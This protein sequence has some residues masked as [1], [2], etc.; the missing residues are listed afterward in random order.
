MKKLLTTALAAIAL[1]APAAHAQLEYK[2]V[3]TIKTDA[4][5]FKSSNIPVYTMDKYGQGLTLYSSSFLGLNS[6]SNIKEISYYGW[7]S[8]KDYNYKYTL[9]VANTDETDV[10]S[11]IIDGPAE[12][13]KATTIV[14]ISR[15]T[16][17]GEINLESQ[18]AIGSSTDPQILLTFT[19]DSGFE[20]TG[21]N[22]IFFVEM[23][24]GMT[25]GISSSYATFCLANNGNA[26]K[27]SVSYRYSPYA[28]DAYGGGYGI[29]T[30]SWSPSR[31][32]LPVM[33]IGYSG[34]ATVITATVNG[35][36]VSSRNQAGLAGA[37]VTLAGQTVTTPSSGLYSFTI[38]NVDNSATYTI[39]VSA[40]GYES[41]SQ[42]VDLR[43]GGE[44]HVDDIVLQ[45]LP[46]PATI[47]GKVLDSS[48]NT[49]VAGAS[50]LFNGTTTVSA[51]DGAYSIAIANV[52]DLPAEGSPLKV[53]AEGFLPYE[54]SLQVTGDM[55]M[56]LLIEPIPAL[57]GNGTLIGSWSLDNF[58]YKAPF[59]PLWAFSQT[60]TLYPT[61]MFA[62]VAA[63]SKFDS[64][65]FYGYYPQSTTP[66]GG[67]EGGDEDDDWGY[68]YEAP[69]RAE[70]ESKT[71][72]V[73][74]YMLSVD[75]T[76]FAVGDSFIPVGDAE[77]LYDG[78]VTLTT[79]G[80]A[81]HP[82]ELFK[83]DFSRPFEYE[84]RPVLLYCDATDG[85]SALAYFCFDG[86]FKSQVLG[87]SASNE[88][89]LETSAASLYTEGMP[90]MRLGN[91]VEA[92]TVSGTVTDIS[93]T[94]PLEGVA[95][96]LTLSGRTVGETV[97]DALGHYSI[98]VSDVRYGQRY[99][100]SFSLDNYDDERSTI[101]FTEAEP[102]VTCDMEM[103]SELTVGVNGID[104]DNSGAD[105]FTVTG[106]RVLTGATA[107]DIDRLPAGIYICRGKKIIVK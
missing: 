64:V 40:E 21:G 98:A 61:E 76:A 43:A 17:F 15:M 72:N 36:V 89:T 34:Q 71:F 14:D 104:A 69:A 3:G 55:N 45:K 20:Y 86:A 5:E 31:S 50:I 7:Q 29:N 75:E 57:P 91:Y 63:G 25:S 24:D 84:G 93:T 67:D 79:G 94:F 30:K 87:R 58:D 101:T 95:V 78:P 11:F 9:Y 85:A 92:P 1:A 73:K 44:I 60:Q 42:T 103:F 96:K 38:P 82:V 22:L 100:L 37:T 51:A 80:E 2:Q 19:C 6:G 99:Q 35:R 77:P 41:T 27:G 49:A 18:E 56:N 23:N 102:D 32:N 65:S 88:P 28:P 62:G 52:D 54:T 53:T 48:N 26:N 107:D 8:A 105:V 16:K 39:G 13:S 97:T 74:L 106:V 90:V 70:A 47:A 68:G 10:S 4:Y 83:V 46:V 81:T 33:R 66:G 59:N 12:G